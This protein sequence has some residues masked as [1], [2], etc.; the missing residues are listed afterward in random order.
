M[1]YFLLCEYIIPIKQ[2]D[3]SILTSCKLSQEY[4]LQSMQIH[5]CA[6][7]YCGIVYI[8]TIKNGH[9]TTRKHKFAKNNEQQYMP[10]GLLH[11]RIYELHKL[12]FTKSVDNS[13]RNTPRQRMINFDHTGDRS[14]IWFSSKSLNVY[15]YTWRNALLGLFS[16]RN[17]TALW[18]F[19]RTTKPQMCNEAFKWWYL[20]GTK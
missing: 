2:R 19:E 7:E 12:H 3:N 10:M 20:P 1:V 11:D 17:S 9:Q 14:R 8:C 4:G 13:A 6:V 15:I 18:F 16:L 5:Y